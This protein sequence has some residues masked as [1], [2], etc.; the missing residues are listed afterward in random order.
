MVK[1]KYFL[2]IICVLVI[3]IITPQYANA[4]PVGTKTR[5]STDRVDIYSGASFN[6]FIEV[7]TPRN[8]N[9]ADLKYNALSSNF[10][11]GNVSFD[12]SRAKGVKVYRWRLPLISNKSGVIKVPKLPISTNLSTP[13]FELK[14]KKTEGLRTKKFIRTQLRNKHLIEGQLAMYRVE[15]DIL[16]DAKIETISEPYAENAT[17][18]LLAEKTIN[19]ARANSPFVYKTRIQEYKVIFNKPG[20][21]VIKSPVVTGYIKSPKNPFMQNAADTTISVGKNNSTGIVSENLNVVVKWMPDES[22][23]TVGQPISRVISIRGTN[24]SLSQLPNIVLPHLEDFD[25]YEDK[26]T[27]TEKLMKNKQ[28]ISTK[29]IRH[30]FIPKKNHT[31]FTLD[32]IKYEWK[33]PNDGAIHT[34][35]IPGVSYSV[36]GFSFNDYIPSNPKYTYWIISGIIA[37][38]FLCVGLYFAAIAYRKRKG[39]FGWL[40]LKLDRAVY[41]YHFNRNWSNIDPFMSRRALLEW[42]QLR[43]P[44]TTIVGLS[45]IPFYHNAKQEIDELSQACWSKEHPQWKGNK[46]YRKICKNKNYQ[47]PKPKHGINPYGINGEIFETVKQKIN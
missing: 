45:N 7:T 24:N 10:T 43:W 17:I 27:E 23:I 42:A 29:V 39:I 20:M 19:R 5:I 12:R 14:I 32:D 13:A 33:N 21:Q 31:T 40:H 35:T 2:A 6:L 44:D 38:L 36:D 30:V 8:L 3:G 18:E 22:E 25:S 26:T 47:K 15:I 16:P 34:I 28:L 11:I 41:W 4:A 37:T 9:K 46:L 1:L